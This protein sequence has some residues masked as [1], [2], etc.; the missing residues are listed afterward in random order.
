MGDLVI[1][2]GVRSAKPP[3]RAP[4]ARLLDAVHKLAWTCSDITGMP[5][6]AVYLP[7]DL[8]LAL[9]KAEADYFGGA[10]MESFELCSVK[11]LPVKD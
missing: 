1:F 11:L 4:G 3:G 2:P 7:E 10:P 5:V 9:A 8:F 6:E